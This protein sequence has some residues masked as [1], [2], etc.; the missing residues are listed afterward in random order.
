[1]V[2]KDLLNLV[3]EFGVD[4]KNLDDL[5]LMEVEF[6]T[7]NREGLVLLSMYDHDGKICIDIGEENE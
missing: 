5:L 1:M 3:L 2:F 4:G 7:S 6:C